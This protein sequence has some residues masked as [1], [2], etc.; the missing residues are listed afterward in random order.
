VNDEADGVVE[1][2]LFDP[3]PPPHETSVA[4]AAPQAAMPTTENRDFMTALLACRK[5]VTVMKTSSARN[6]F[7]E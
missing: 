1:L 4:R 5:A 7:L 2:V 6:L 3:E